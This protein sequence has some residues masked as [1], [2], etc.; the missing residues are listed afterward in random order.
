MLSF[1]GDIADFVHAP[2]NRRRH[3]APF[4]Y[5]ESTF[6]EHAYLLQYTQPHCGEEV[7]EKS[8]PN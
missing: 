4:S 5:L 3:V 6:A 8:L 7:E 1:L 2:I